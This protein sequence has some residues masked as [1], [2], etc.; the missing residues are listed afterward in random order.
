[1]SFLK[2]IMTFRILVIE[3]EIE[4]AQAIKME[5]LSEDYEVDRKSVV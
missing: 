4:M 3:D 5:L 2:R 1:M